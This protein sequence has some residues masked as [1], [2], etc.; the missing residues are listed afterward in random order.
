MSKKDKNSDNLEK[1]HE[2]RGNNDILP[3]Q[4]NQH[5]NGFVRRKHREKR[6]HG[7]HGGKHKSQNT[8][9]IR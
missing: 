9:S 6:F 1:I 7:K 4:T 3:A 5:A 8:R 2:T